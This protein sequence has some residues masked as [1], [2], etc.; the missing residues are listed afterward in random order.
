MTSSGSSDARSPSTSRSVPASKAAGAVRRGPGL[1][2][3]LKRWLYL[4]HR[5]IGIGSCI[6]FAMWFASGLVMIYVPYPSLSQGE[7]LA[8]A[9]PI[10]WARV[11]V[12][13]PIDPA[14]TP[15]QLD[16]AMRDGSPVWRVQEW[17]G[18][19]RLVSADRAVAEPHVNAAYARRVANRFGNAD[20]LAVAE[21]ERDQWTVAGG[22][23]RHRPLWKV[24]MAD[25][26]K[27]ELY[28]SSSTGDIV[29]S[30]TRSERLWN[31]LGSVPHWIY[32]TIL[33]Q[34]QSAWRQTV[35]WISGPCIAAAIT[36]MW[37][38][39][40]RTRVGQRRFKGG[41]MTPYHGW[42]LWHHVAG[43]VGGIFLTLW[44]FS[45]WLSVDPGHLFTSPDPAEGVEQRYS[46]GKPLPPIDVTRLSQAAAGARLV[47]VSDHAG[48]P[49]VTL[50]GADGARRVLALPSL[51]P[52]VPQRSAIEQ[53]AKGLV[54][55]GKLADATLLTEPDA[56][57]YDIG[58]KPRLPALRLRFADPDRTWLYLDPVTG[59]VLN[60]VDTRRRTYRWLYDM[61]HKWDL[62]V[63][64]LNRPLWDIL[65]WAFSLIGLVTSVSGVWIG[66]KRLRR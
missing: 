42:M 33:R 54:P 19:R 65:L 46:S 55:A 39:I 36:G 21:L 23:D 8:R 26:V 47:S 59:E 9:Q 56:Y 25:P 49:S 30:T 24:A 53:A 7:W 6:L 16:L 5:W 52:A 51:S 38:G 12:A 18:E 43:L 61:F 62:N 45:G 14:R 27:T 35:L 64:T 4:I 34:D 57:Y 63:L 41:R 58:A 48:L 37:I 28:V 60:G 66:W 50:F 40:L 22:F 1:G 32:P 44:I 15:R 31:W 17:S 11:T 10:D 3:A 2:H 20:V 29:Q 13:P